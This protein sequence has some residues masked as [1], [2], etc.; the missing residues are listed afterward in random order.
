MVSHMAHKLPKDWKP[1]RDALNKTP[2]PALTKLIKELYDLHPD[3]RKFLHARYAPTPSAD[4]K[5]LA[6]HRKALGSLVAAPAD[7][8]LGRFPFAEVREL[9]RNYEKAS[10]DADGATGLLIEAAY[11]GLKIAGSNEMDSRYADGLY[12][13][14]NHLNKRLSTPEGRHLARKHQESIINLATPAGRIGYG[15]GDE[16][17]RWIDEVLK[18]L[19]PAEPQ[20][21]FDGDPDFDSV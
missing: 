21:R 8:Y 7:G 19:P 14:L 9:V 4:P 11:R 12:S 1:V 10:F 20:L 16:V 6:K 3:V 2:R 15:F 5:V 18:D 17:P 13:L